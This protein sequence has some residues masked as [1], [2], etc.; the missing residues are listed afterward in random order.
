MVYVD[1]PGEVLDRAVKLVEEK[2]VGEYGSKARKFVDKYSWFNLV[3]EY[4]KT[5]NKILFKK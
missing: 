2:L 5:L 4:E 3:D 1:S